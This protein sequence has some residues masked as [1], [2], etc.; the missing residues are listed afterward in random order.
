MSARLV[1]YQ[2]AFL[3][4]VNHTTSSQAGNHSAASI[5]PKK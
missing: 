4:K 2:P 5:R 3:G 1:F